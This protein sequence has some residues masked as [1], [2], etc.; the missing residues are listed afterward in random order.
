MSQPRASLRN[1][2]SV[3][4]YRAERS[5]CLPMARAHF[6]LGAVVKNINR[7]A[8]KLQDDVNKLIEIKASLLATAV[9][10]GGDEQ[11]S[12]RA[13]AE[14]IDIESFKALIDT[15]SVQNSPVLDA[16]TAASQN[17]ALLGK[18]AKNLEGSMATKT[19]TL[20]G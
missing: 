13:I 5:H 17:C 10:S 15:L 8:D 12:A 7:A 14:M 16:L 19:L 9:R 18:P 11:E 4:E 1:T 3:T 6:D 2:A 20:V